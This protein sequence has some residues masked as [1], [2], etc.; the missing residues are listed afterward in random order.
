M[1][2]EQEHA[3]VKRLEEIGAKHNIN[4]RDIT[5]AVD[6]LRLGVLLAGIVGKPVA[7]GM[8]MVLGAL[9]SDQEYETVV[10]DFMAV[11]REHG[12]ATI[13]GLKSGVN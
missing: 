2:T 10:R 4:P 5:I 8:A 9:T 7:A 1:N 3:I 6:A 12:S 13:P 11:G